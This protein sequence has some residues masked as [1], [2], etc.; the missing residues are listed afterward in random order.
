[1]HTARA[2]WSP[3]PGNIN[4][5]VLKLSSYVEQLG[6]TG[7][8][9]SEFVNP[10]YADASKTAF[11]SSTRLECM[12]QVGASMRRARVCLLRR[13]MACALQLCSRTRLCVPTALVRHAVM[14]ALRKRACLWLCCGLVSAGLPQGA[15]GGRQ[16][17]LHGRQ[18]GAG[19]RA[20]RPRGRARSCMCM[21]CV[22]VAAALHRNG[23]PACRLPDMA[24]KSCFFIC[25]CCCISAASSSSRSGVGNVLARQELAGGRAR[26][27]GRGQPHAQRHHGCGAAGCVVVHACVGA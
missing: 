11:K 8:V 15:A 5:L 12:M 17:W 16:G 20:T 7:G 21:H 24:C 23:G 2:G 1:M 26:K 25:R 19:R 14:P 9:I 4:Q 6:A 3:F 27:G 10:K 18:A 22:S 13:Q